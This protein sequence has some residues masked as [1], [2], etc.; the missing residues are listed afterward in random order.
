MQAA[1]SPGLAGDRAVAVIGIAC[2]LPGGANAHAFWELLRDGRD[3]FGSLSSRWQWPANIDPH[4]SHAGIDRAGLLPRVD[5]FDAAFFQI[6]P[7]EAEL[8]DPQHR[9]LLELGWE[10]MERSGYRPAQLATRRT[11]V[12]VG[13]AHY[14]YRDLLA[15]TTA[16]TDAYVATGSSPSMLANRLSYFYDFR[17]PSVSIDTACSSSL[18]AL[19]LAVQALRA[20]ECD[21]ALLAAV[22]LICSPVTS[23]AYYEAGMLSRSGVCR[24]FDH[25]AD[26]YVRGEGAVALLLK[27]LRQALADRD[28]VH[29]VI[30]GAAVGHGGRAASLTAPKPA[31]QAAVIE[32][33][34]RDA[35]VDAD[36]VQFVEAHGTGTQLG[37]VVEIAGLQQAFKRVR[38]APAHIDARSAVASAR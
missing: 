32:A 29:G 27:P 12:F 23:I 14:D 18:V 7:H 36:R 15:R 11:G 21:H 13:V 37:D 38:G 30:L 6:S 20:G 24:A 35:G 34:L 17:G 10:V 28:V 9:L 33:A 1:A 22:N 3:A 26:G 2:R 19:E 8:M 16:A 5:E 4:G 31:S 25:H